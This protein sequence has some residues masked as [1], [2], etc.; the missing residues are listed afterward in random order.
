MADGFNNRVVR[1]RE[2]GEGQVT[3]AFTG[4]N[5]PTGLAFPPVAARPGHGHDR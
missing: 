4:L 1:V 5:T 3:L 2:T